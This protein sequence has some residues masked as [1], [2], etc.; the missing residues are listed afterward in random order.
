MCGGL[1]EGARAEVNNEGRKWQNSCAC[2]RICDLKRWF[3]PTGCGYKVSVVLRK[4][5]FPLYIEI[6]RDQ[7]VEGPQR[8]KHLY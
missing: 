1:G 6:I 3:C 4:L 7:G 2:D 5:Y 8:R